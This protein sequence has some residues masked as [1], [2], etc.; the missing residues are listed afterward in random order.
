MTPTIKRKEAIKFIK[1]YI[2]FTQSEMQLHRLMTEDE[3]AQHSYTVWASKEC[4]RYINRYP[5]LDVL[6][7]VASFVETMDSYCLKNEANNWMFSVAYDA[8]MNIYDQLLW[9]YELNDWKGK[10][11]GQQLEDSKCRRSLRS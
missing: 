11:D 7:A 9:F 8:A 6:D 3:F 5:T 4:L 1:N 10:S 2:Q